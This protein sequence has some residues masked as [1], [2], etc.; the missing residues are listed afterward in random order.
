MLTLLRKHAQSWLIKLLLGVIVVTFVISFGVGTFT[1]NKAVVARL[2]SDEILLNEFNQRYQEELDALRR[3]FPENAEQIAQQL[4][5]REKVL[6]RMIDRRLLLEEAEREGLRITDRELK[7]AV[8][9]TKTFQIGDRFDF[10]TYRTVLSQNRMTPESYEERLRE[11]L[12][13]TRYQRSLMAG[14]L[15]GEPEIDLRYRIEHEKVEVDYVY[16]NPATFEKGLTPSAD[17]EKAYFEA[18][19][20]EFTQ[21][22][23]YRIA[24]LVLS[25]AKLEQ[26]VSVRDR[27]VERYYELHSEDE[28]STPKRVRASHI[29]KQVPPGAT[30]E[31]EAKLREAFAPVLQEARAGKDFAALARKY[32]DDPSKAKGGDLGFFVQADMV[33]EFAAAAFAL[34]RGQVSEIVRSPFGFH[35]IKATEIQP[36]VVKPLAAVRAQIAERLR[37]ERAERKLDLEAERLPQRIEKEG[38]EA[39]A[40]TL[41]LQVAETPWFDGT[42]VLP[43]LGSSAPLHALL[44]VRKAGDISAWRRN[45]Q[46]GHVFFK[47]LETKPARQKELDEVRAELT[48]LVRAGQAVERALADAREAFKTLRQPQQLAAYAKRRGLALKTATFTAVDGSLP[49]LGANREFQQAAFRLSAE[50]PFG[51]GIKDQHAYL[52]HLKRRYLPKSQEEAGLKRR[53]AGQIQG[54]LERYLLSR[55]V[56][57]LKTKTKVEIVAPEL[58]STN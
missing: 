53:I 12:L 32:S 21:P 48:R 24:Y 43:G 5:M 45:P 1:A 6:E 56:E 14:V 55:E 15:I 37:V 29:L 3:R 42:G 11:D 41:G 34:E 51:L 19:R 4:K 20:K 36:A 9:R 31:Q 54:E 18:H 40:K 13:L 50:Q 23:Q 16:A 52:I 2:G 49:E 44:K 38:L 47:V 30:P 10:E 17:A 57:R 25:A 46:Q 8:A 27:A 7:D 26:G 35:I 28:F 58:I 33:P 22:P 39:V